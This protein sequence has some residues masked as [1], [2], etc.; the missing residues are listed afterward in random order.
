MLKQFH[1][2]QNLS[3]IINSAVMNVTDG[4]EE[5]WKSQWPGFESA[6]KWVLLLAY[7]T[8]PLARLFLS[9]VA[10]V[11]KGSNDL[12]ALSGRTWTS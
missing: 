5:E 12:Y 4:L 3:K 6:V 10:V 7:G 8:G 9:P 1:G 2:P 11:D